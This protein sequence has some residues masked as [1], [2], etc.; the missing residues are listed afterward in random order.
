MINEFDSALRMTHGLLLAYDHVTEEHINEAV[1]QI[2]LLQLGGGLQSV[3]LDVLKAK[4]ME[5]FH[6]T[7]EHARILEGKERRM[8]WLR[9][10]KAEE[11]SNWHFWEDY[12]KYL[13][14]V[15]LFPN[16]VVNELEDL[17]DTILDKLFDPNQTNV[18][19]QKKGMEIHYLKRLKK[20]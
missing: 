5:M 1:E 17:T 20:D 11:K 9:A 3:D 15:K 4:L 14:E 19:L 8:P 2:R 13:K 16:A 10:F 18:V 7:I 12:K 6:A